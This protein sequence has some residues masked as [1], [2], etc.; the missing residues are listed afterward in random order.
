[1]WICRFFP[2]HDFGINAK[3][4]GSH[5]RVACPPGGD[6][7]GVKLVDNIC[8]AHSRLAIVDLSSAGHQP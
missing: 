1:M 8:L 6:D 7:F 2:A 5:G 3:K 4:I